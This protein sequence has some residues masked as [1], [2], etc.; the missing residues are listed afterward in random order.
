MFKKL[1]YF[2]AWLFVL[3]LLL[4]FCF[5][6]G[7]WQNWS[8]ATILICWLLMLL[9]SL[10]LWGT[11]C[12]TS[13]IIK[14]KQGH[15]WLGKYRLS[16]R[17]YVLFNH[18]QRGA[19]IIKRV[20]R[21]RTNLPWYLLVGDRCGK[22]TLL[23]SSGLPRFDGD[24]DI[25]NGPTRTLRWWF[26][27]QV[28]VLDLSSNFIKGAIPCRQAWGKLVRWCTRVPA[29][30]GIIVALPIGSLMSDDLSGLHQL[31][32]QKRTLIEPLIR[33]FGERLPLYVLVTQCDNFPG[34]RLW[35][36]Q[37]SA[38]QRQQPLGYTWQTSPHIDGQD[39]LALQPLFAALKQG[40]SLVRLSMASQGALGA[41][42]RAT[43][44]DFPESFARLEP[45]LRYVLASLCEPNA[46]FSHIHLSSV[47]FSATEPQTE[48][49]GRRA[50]IFIHDLLTV[51][52][53]EL[54]LRYAGQRWY[55]RRRGKIA[56]TTALVVCFIWIAVSASL[57]FKR[58]QPELAQLPPDAL[59]RFLDK[60]ERFPTTALL[61]LPFQPL[62]EKQRDLA[63]SL[64]QQKSYASRIAHTAFADFQ[65][66]VL[67]AP[68]ARQRELILQLAHAIQTWQQM[69]EGISLEEVSQTEDIATTLRQRTYT[70]ALSPLAIMALERYYIQRPEGQHWLQTARRLLIMLVNHDPALN[71]LVAP[72]A[73]FPAL[74]G[75]LFWPSLQGDVA[76]SGIWTDVGEKKLNGWMMQIESAI[77]QTQPIFQ[78]ARREWPTQRQNAWQQYLLDI[79]ASLKSAPPTTL[80]REQLIAIAHNQSLAMQFVD[81]IIDELKSIPEERAQPWLVT[82]RQLQQLSE[83]EQISAL[84]KRAN[85]VDNRVRQ[86]LSAWLRGTSLKLRTDSTAPINVMW[87]QWQKVRNGAVKEAIAQGKPSALL[88]RGLFSP[89]Q[90]SGEPNPLSEMFP[91]LATLQELLSPQTNDVSTEAVWMLYQDDARR[92][93]GHAMAQSACWLNNQWKSVVLWPLDKNNKLHSYEEQQAQSHQLVN[94][95]LRG[96]AKALLVLGSNGPTVADY[97]G[98]QVPLLDDFIDLTRKSFSSE[99]MQDIPQRNST[100]DNDQKVSLQ[101]KLDAL[102][103]KQNEL[104]KKKWKI[105][106][107]SL[108]ATVPGGAKIIPTG[109][110]LILS[111]QNG[112]QQLN[113]MNFAEKHDFS[114]QP[115]Q[116]STITLIVMFPGFTASYQV[117]GDDA[118][119]WFVE[120][121]ADGEELLDAKDF[122]DGSDS[123][124][125][126][127]IK[128]VLVRFD[129]SSPDAIRTAWETWNTLTGEIDDLRVQIASLDE[130]A[131]KDEYQPISELPSDIA[132]CQ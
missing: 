132:Q 58:L 24:S 28:C 94:T 40:M 27:R 54:S 90:T 93:L 36:Q 74:P 124:N 23:A 51:H 116:C 34:F 29:P 49:N 118:M 76:L 130:R 111:C 6:L 18:W 48:N 68:P 57:S 128:Q 97:A 39:E 127:Q 56:C 43:L 65:H 85:Q 129:L 104:E 26:F 84:V 96:P 60:D 2:T 131:A 55:Q 89:E 19:S 99:M 75:S 108:P 80:S 7:L 53:R 46:Y 103:L 77:G 64:L 38:V 61:Y 30:A 105:S 123:L 101:A 120:S 115:G 17:E 13:R 50:G 44:L 3:S 22:S 95:F 78:Q 126:L 83:N 59:A 112:D 91:V 35:Y 98:M 14:G 92:L 88:I 41:Q 82:L 125:Q 72:S 63:G 114:W 79:T 9:L 16:H 100:F 52:L 42:E 67:K 31:A 32:R 12:A 113:S 21:R 87:Q 106:V 73:T 121:F 4:I 1:A 81:R 122:H 117:N 119:Q 45:N 110:Q 109:T 71:W 62:L 107:T 47:W 5:T 102:V 8:T 11:V 25:V 37:L 70:D 10:L 20:Y 33:R 66:Q 69:R 15:R 86:S